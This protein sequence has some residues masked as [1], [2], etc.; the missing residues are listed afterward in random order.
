MRGVFTTVLAKLGSKSRSLENRYVEP[1]EVRVSLVK[2]MIVAAMVI[3][4]G[5][6]NSGRMWT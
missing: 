2:K 5:T 4:W 3:A 6:H 1:G